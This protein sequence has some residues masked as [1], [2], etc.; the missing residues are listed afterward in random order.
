MDKGKAQEC[1][2]KTYEALADEYAKDHEDNKEIRK[3]AKIFCS[4]LPE[5]GKIIDV[6]CGPGRDMRYFLDQGYATT[7]ID[8][9]P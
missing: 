4:F 1:T 8:L 5:N 3:Y 7:G 2:I 9:Y 6:G